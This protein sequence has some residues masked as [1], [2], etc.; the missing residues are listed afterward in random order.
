MA[1]RNLSLVAFSLY[2]KW[3]KKAPL[4]EG[5]GARQVLCALKEGKKA[6]DLL[7]S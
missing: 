4:S 7:N 5:E 1:T 3:P 6:T 2:G